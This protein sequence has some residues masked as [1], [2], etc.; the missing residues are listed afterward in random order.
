MPQVQREGEI[1]IFDQRRRRELSLRR[2][3]R[4]KAGEAARLRF[5]AVDWK[6]VVAAPAGMGHMILAASK[7]TAV[8]GVV[9]IEHQ[10][11]VHTDGRLQTFRRLPRAIT[12]TGNTLAIGG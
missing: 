3:M 8:P 6:G 10:R 7:G 11:G 12:H 9:E 2:T 4:E 1:G 5:V